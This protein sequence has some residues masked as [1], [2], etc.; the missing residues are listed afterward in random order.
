MAHSEILVF[1]LL[2]LALFFI[3]F[4]SIVFFWQKFNSGENNNELLAHLAELKEGQ[5][6]LSGTVEVLSNNQN[7]SSAHL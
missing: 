7:S 4:A 5:Q 2:G 1:I 3:V 6:K